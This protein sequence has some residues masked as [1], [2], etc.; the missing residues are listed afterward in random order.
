[1]CEGLSLPY[2]AAG[3]DVKNVWDL[4]RNEKYFRKQFL[5]FLQ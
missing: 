3:S 1:M 5:L 4:R 2:L